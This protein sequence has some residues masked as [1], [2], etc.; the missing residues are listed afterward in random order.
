M[1]TLTE[2]AT[3]VVKGIADQ[4][5]EASGLR[6]TGGPAEEPSLEVAPASAAEPGDQ[7]VEQE[8]ATVYLDENA[9]LLLDDKVLDARVDEEGRVEFA[10][11][12]QG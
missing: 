1:L 9:V 6:I 5:P 3:A 12:Q 2:N 4:V 7:V 10:L 8:G 11:G